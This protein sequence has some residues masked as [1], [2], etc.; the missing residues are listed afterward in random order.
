MTPPT[1]T[2]PL[3]LSAPQASLSPGLKSGQMRPA[4][5]VPLCLPQAE[6]AFFTGGHLLLVTLQYFQVVALCIMFSLLVVFCRSTVIRS[7]L[8]HCSWKW[9]R[10]TLSCQ[11]FSQWCVLLSGMVSRALIGI[12]FN[13]VVHSSGDIHSSWLA[14]KLYRL[15]I[16]VLEAHH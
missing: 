2:P 13:D 10:K 1:P 5:V 8:S 16:N 9:K 11:Y 3:P 4:A 12:L 6:L 7:H 14:R 15:K